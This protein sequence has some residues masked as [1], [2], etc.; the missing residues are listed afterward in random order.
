MDNLFSEFIKERRYLHNLA[1][2]TLLYYTQTYTLFK[3]VNAF[4]NF[5]K[6]SIQAGVIQMRER[7]TSIGAIN[8]YLRGL[9]TFLKWL[10]RERGYPDHS[11][12][13]LKNQKPVLRALT[14]SYE[15]FLTF[16]HPDRPRRSRKQ[17]R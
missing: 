14:G 9:N 17:I 15:K 1:E 12:K 3:K 8:T 10:H 4:D 11:L 16:V 6:H 13:L 5:S 2:S 7:G